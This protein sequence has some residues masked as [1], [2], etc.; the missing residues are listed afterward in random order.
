MTY[1]ENAKLWLNRPFDQETI[2]QVKE[3]Q[4]NPEKLEDAFYTNLSF[5][6][7]GMRGVMGM[8]TNRIN[9]YTLGK[10]SQGL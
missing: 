8:G 2:T 9:K 5:G 4:E 7:G 10:A 3:L 6:T 1:Q